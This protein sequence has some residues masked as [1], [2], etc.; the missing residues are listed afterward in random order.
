MNFPQVWSARATEAV[1]T[2]GGKH[3]LVPKRKGWWVW[4]VK[5]CG[6][7]QAIEDRRFVVVVVS[8]RELGWNF[9]E[10]GLV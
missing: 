9:M 2:L 5:M 3:R 4:W 6:Q 7:T 8:G 1:M 10:E